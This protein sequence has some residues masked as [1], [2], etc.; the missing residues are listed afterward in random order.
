MEHDFIVGLLF[1]DVYWHLNLSPL[2]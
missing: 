1:K 2:F